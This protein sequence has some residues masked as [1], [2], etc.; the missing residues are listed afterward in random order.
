[1][2][3]TTA[4]ARKYKLQV[5]T[6][7]TLT[8]GW[9]NVNGLLDFNDPFSPNVV[10][11]TDYDTSGYGSSEITVQGYV[12][13]GTVRH[14][15][16]S[17]VYDPGQELLRLARGQFST[18]A[19][20]GV[21]WFDRFGGPEANSGVA[22]LT[23]WQRATTGTKDAENMQFALTGTDVPPNL[24][25]TNPYTTTLAPVVF[26]ATPSGQ[27]AAKAVLI[28]GANFTGATA[29]TFGGTAATTFTVQNDQ[30]ITA[31]L[32]AGS[33]GAANIV[34]TTPAGSNP[35]FAYTRTV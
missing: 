8:T 35:G 22:L 17:N 24:N 25:I 1:M 14:L 3:N 18:A 5:T 11:V 21:R 23:Q 9:V 33:A 12:L 20:L 10:D 29:V 27:G 28:T 4:L 2:S 19:R 7:L 31:V 13:S 32:P 26:S 15:V 30:L 34:V 6:D 16:N